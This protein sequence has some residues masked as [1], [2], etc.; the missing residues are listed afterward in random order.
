MIRERAQIALKAQK[1]S[2]M[3]KQGSKFAL[4]MLKTV[5]NDTFLSKN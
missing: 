1:L 2:I 4:V 5:E 3:K